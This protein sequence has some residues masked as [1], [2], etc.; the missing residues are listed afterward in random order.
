LYQ[1]DLSRLR[2]GFSSPVSDLN[3]CGREAAAKFSRKGKMTKIK[4]F[5]MKFNNET[6]QFEDEDLQFFCSENIIHDSEHHFFIVAQNQFI[7][8]ILTYEEKETK[9]NQRQI[10]KIKKGKIDLTEI[11][12]ALFNKLKHMRNEKAI[13]IGLPSY[14]LGTNREI[15][16]I[17]RKRCV[18]IESLRLIEGFGKRKINDVGKEFIAVI[19]KK[20][21]R[22][23]SD[24]D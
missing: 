6:E 22:E 1:R 7:T 3:P 14:V 17:V 24:N 15:A 10:Y 13:S 4:I 8:T 11:E 9:S 23:G 12:L 5:T 2:D 20:L 19:K 18:T 16:E 21:E